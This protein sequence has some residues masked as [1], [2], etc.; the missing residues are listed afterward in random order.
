MLTYKKTGL[1][2]EGIMDTV[3]KAAGFDDCRG[4][5]K[6]ADLI[7]LAD[8]VR[9]GRAQNVASKTKGFKGWPN[10]TAKFILDRV[11]GLDYIIETM[12]NS[13]LVGF[14]FSTN[15]EETASKASKL[16]SFKPL[17]KA[18]GLTKVVVLTT[19][20]PEGEDQGVVFYDTDAAVDNLFDIIFSAVEAENDV[21]V[22]TLALTYKK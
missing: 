4:S 13:E 9:P 14:D 19:I 11:Y 15:E 21:S 8:K 18:L 17:W 5:F 22:S 10:Y 2:N 16:E 6:S 12:P 1:F 20:Y 7:S 3:F